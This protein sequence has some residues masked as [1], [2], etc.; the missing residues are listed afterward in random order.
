MT[1]YWTSDL[2]LG[3]ERICK[4][5]E[6]PF[7]SVE[8][9]NTELVRRWNDTVGPDDDVIVLGDLAMGRFAETLELVAMLNGRKLLVPGNHDRV[10]PVYN[11]RRAHKR[12]VWSRM[13]FEAGV[14]ILPCHIAVRLEGRLVHACHFPYDED[15]LGRT[16]YDE[17]RPK[18][19]GHWL[20]HGHTH[21]RGQPR[22]LRNPV[23]GRQVDVG[24]D[25]WDFRPISDWQIQAEIE[26]AS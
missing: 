8:E 4:L 24:V 23:H 26:S 22:G 14:Q 12:L 18:D 3:H 21:G 1:R 7:A 15:D 16:E 13:Y 2:H 5:A 11:D 25:L 20:L 19:E 17:Y 6:R 10:H 9:M